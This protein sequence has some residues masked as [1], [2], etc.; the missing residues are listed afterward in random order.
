LNNIRINYYDFGLMRGVETHWMVSQ[1]FPGL[2][3]TNYRVYGFEA[4]KE[5]A[6]RLKKIYKGNDKVE[7][8]NKAIVDTSKKVKLYHAPNHVGHSVFSTKN[9]VSNKFEEV[10]GVS[11]SSWLRNNV[12]DYEEAFNIIKV[13]I[14]GA[15]WYL[16]NDLVDSGIHSHVDI[17]C[18][19]GHDVKK[20]SE[21]E[22]KVES[23]YQLL[24]DNN[25][26]LYR[27]TEYKPH[28]NDD[29]KSIIKEK[30][31]EYSPRKC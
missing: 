10:E 30:L 6:D 22:E 20:V 18:G 4:C 31:N 13:N 5:Y 3:I 15:E 25:I 19:Q 26:H 16:F 14:E 12:K 2:N 1:V 29:I 8:I 28:K 17:Y 24:A 9:N 11:F 7:I 21:L 23:Y 27:F